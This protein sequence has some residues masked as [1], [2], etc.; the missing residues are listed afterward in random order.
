[1]S[2]RTARRCFCVPCRFCPRGGIPTVCRY[3]PLCP[4]FHSGC[5]SGCER[6]SALSQRV[7]HHPNPT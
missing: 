4:A 3:P 2:R 7:V 5:Q 1:M 6:T